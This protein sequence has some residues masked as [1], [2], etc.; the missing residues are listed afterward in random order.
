MET[1]LWHSTEEKTQNSTN[2]CWLPE[3][4]LYS[5]KL[6]SGKKELHKELLEPT[7]FKANYMEVQINRETTWNFSRV[8]DAFMCS[9]WNVTSQILSNP[10]FLELSSYFLKKKKVQ[11]LLGNHC[12]NIWRIRKFHLSFVF[13]VSCFLWRK[14]AKLLPTASVI[15]VQS[16]WSPPPELGWRTQK[17][18]MISIIII[19]IIIQHYFAE[20]YLFSR[21]A[22]LVFTHL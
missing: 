2:S 5:S 19:I 9:F 3:L 12:Y 15:P 14:G 11:Q 1:S 18:C 10:V 6:C 21:N 4:Y 20:T 7:N 17:T 13:P 22:H 8:F 16:C